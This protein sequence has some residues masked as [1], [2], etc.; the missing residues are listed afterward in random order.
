MRFIISADLTKA[1]MI[2]TK[3]ELVLDKSVFILAKMMNTH[4]FYKNTNM[5]DMVQDII[6]ITM[7]NG[8][9]CPLDSINP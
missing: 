2:G 8:R 1:D 7:Y 3:K 6:Y 5:I 9:L 4:K